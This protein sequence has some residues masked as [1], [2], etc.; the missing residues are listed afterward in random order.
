MES[1]EF[2][3]STV[4]EAIE[5][6]LKELGK[7]QDEVDIEIADIGGFLKKAKVIMTLKPTEGE[8]AVEFVKQLMQ[9]MKFDITPS[10]EETD[11]KVVISLSGKDSGKVIG[12][13]GDVLDAIQ[14]ITSIAVNAGNES[15]KKIVVDCENYRTKREDTLVQLAE[16]LAR[17]ATN[18]GRIVALEPMNPFE[19]RIIHSA[20]QENQNV[21]TESE[22]EEPN[23]HVV[24]KPKQ[25]VKDGET[26]QKAYGKKKLRGGDRAAG[27]HDRKEGKGSGGRNDRGRGRSEGGFRGRSEKS[28][29]PAFTGFGT[30]LG[31]SKSGFASDGSLLKKSNFDNLKD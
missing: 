1:L 20:L 9:K 3:A 10:L 17:K 16:R 15:F 7:K 21:T 31:N 30:Y 18:Q 13:R 29:R 23:R 2:K 5:K 14:Y 11:E 6:G 4:E 8:K 26:G 22:G 28:A 27:G 12:Y 24:I 25:L 19:R